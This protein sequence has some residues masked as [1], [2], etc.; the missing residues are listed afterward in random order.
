MGRPGDV[1]GA[2]RAVGIR[3][4]VRQRHRHGHVSVR[5]PYPEADHLLPVI[6]GEEMRPPFSVLAPQQAAESIAVRAVQRDE[7]ST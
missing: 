6:V 5:A 2:L 4:D 1:A 3:F 7:T